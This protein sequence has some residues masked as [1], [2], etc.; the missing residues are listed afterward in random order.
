MSE[1]E[2]RDGAVGAGRQQTAL[3]AQGRPTTTVPVIPLWERPREG[4]C[5]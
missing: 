3:R 4:A 5:R 1:S 2:Q